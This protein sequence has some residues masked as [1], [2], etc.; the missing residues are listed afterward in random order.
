MKGEEISL[1]GEMPNLTRDSVETFIKKNIKLKIIDTAGFT[2]TRI[3]DNL[4]EKLSMDITKKK[5]RLSKFILIVI[6][7]KTI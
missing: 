2:K 3:K 5:I 4:V 7:I 6:D 1:T